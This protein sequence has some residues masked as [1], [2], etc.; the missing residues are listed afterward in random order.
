MGF[1]TKRKLFK[2]GMWATF[3]FVV[4]EFVE[5]AF[6][7]LVA[8]LISNTIVFFAVKTLTALA[9]IKTTELATIPIEKGLLAFLRKIFYEKEKNKVNKLKSVLSKVWNFVFT[10]KCSLGSIFVAVILA[11]SGSSVIDV[12]SLPEMNIATS[13]GTPAI[14]QETDEIATEIVYGKEAVI[15]TEIVYGAPVFATEKI[16]AE[17]TIATEQIFAEDT[18]AT[19]IVYEVEPVY[20]TEIVYEVEPVI[21]TEI[22]YAVE[23]VY[24]EKLTFV[25]KEIIY[26]IDGVTVK[27]NVGDYVSN[28]EVVD[29]MD[30]VSVFNKGDVIKEGLVLYNIGDVVKEGIILYNVGD[31]ITEGVVLYNIGDTI[32]GELL[33]DIG[34][35]IPGELLYD[36]GDYM[37]TEILFNVGDVVE[38]A[39]ILFNVGDVITPAGTVLVEEISAETFNLTPVLFWVMLSAMVVVCGSFFENPQEFAKRIAEKLK[40]K[41]EKE[42]IKIAKKEVEAE[43]KSFL[44]EQ[45][46]KVENAE[47]AQAETER[48]YKIE[49]IKAQIK[50][51]K[52]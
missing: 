29:I 5:S 22:I 11:L 50:A 51:G 7:Y 45:K 10:N 35:T 36:V 37:Y 18:I 30:K 16:Y 34:D 27:Y 49:E 46:Q 23:P 39:E 12:N 14:I 40:I 52:I 8:F 33:Y 43:Q 47:K 32:P 9:I 1:F 6:E 19:E 24:A 4:W 3:T 44:A 25:A 48:R 20:A 15:A 42:N 38:P 41:E 13:K 26:D 21:A 31:V 28:L 17:P 2:G